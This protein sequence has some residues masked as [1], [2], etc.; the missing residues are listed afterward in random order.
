MQLS[1]VPRLIESSGGK[2][3][4]QAVIIKVEKIEEKTRKQEFIDFMYFN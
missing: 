4:P 1:Y 2:F 3:N